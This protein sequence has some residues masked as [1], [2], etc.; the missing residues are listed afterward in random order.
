MHM[1]KQLCRPT[2][3]LKGALR[4]RGAG[5]ALRGAFRGRAPPNESCAPQARTV[6]PRNLLARGYRSAN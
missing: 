3:C 6:P 5:P 1:V 4:S 2:A